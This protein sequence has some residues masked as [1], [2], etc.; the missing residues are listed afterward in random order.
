MYCCSLSITAL[1]TPTINEN[2]SS[3]DADFEMLDEIL[4]GDARMEL[5]HAGGEW[6]DVEEELETTLSGF[7]RYIYIN[8]VVV[9]F[10][11]L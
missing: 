8:P 3:L 5:S 7:P 6:Q 9:I 11:D 2:L 4:V 10:R 1:Y